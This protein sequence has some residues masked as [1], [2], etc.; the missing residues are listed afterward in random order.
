MGALTELKG[1]EL[2]STKVRIETHHRRDGSVR[3]CSPVLRDPRHHQVAFAPVSNARKTKGGWYSVPTSCRAS[4]TGIMF[5]PA[6]VR[7]VQREASG[8]QS[9]RLYDRH[10]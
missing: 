7:P 2:G 3:R 8:R 6:R 4:K 10:R 1:T 5:H 9:L